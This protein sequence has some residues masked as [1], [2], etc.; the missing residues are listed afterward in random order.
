[1]SKRDALVEKYTEQITE[2]LGQKVDKKLL[3]GVTKACGPSIYNRDASTVAFTDPKEVDRV[4]KNFVQKKMGVKAGDKLD[5]GVEA[6]M[7]EY[8]K[9]SRTRYRAVFYYLLAKQFRKGAMFK[10]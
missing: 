5:A 4:K 1:M 6:A 10:G 7:A 3:V 8:K 2:K 9:A